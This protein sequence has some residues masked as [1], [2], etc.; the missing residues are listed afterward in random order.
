M[1]TTPSTSTTSTA[2]LSCVYAAHSNTAVKKQ[3]TGGQ[4]LKCASYGSEAAYLDA[5]KASCAADSRCH[6]FVDDPTDRRGRMC[7]PKSAMVGYAKLQK[8]FYVKGG[9]C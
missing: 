4:K 3:G 6:G 1:T 2:A 8:T 5:C 9:E 7:K